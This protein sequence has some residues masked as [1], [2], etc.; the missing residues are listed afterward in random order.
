MMGEWTHL[1]PAGE[2]PSCMPTSTPSTPRS[3]SGT[4]DAERQAG[5]GGNRRGP[6]GLVR[7]QGRR[8]T[9]GDERG[10]TPT[11]LPNAM[12]IPPRMKAYSA[13]SKLVMAC[14]AY[15]TPV[16]EGLSVDEAFLDVGGSKASWGPRETA[17]EL[18]VRVARGRSPISVGIAR[19]KFLAKVASAPAKPDGLIEVPA[20]REL[21]F[22]DPLPVECVWGVGRVTSRQAAGGRDRDCRP[23]RRPRPRHPGGS[24]GRRGRPPPPCSR[25]QP[26]PTRR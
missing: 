14:F 1:R 7:G 4:S 25:P 26:G 8:R 23:D 3:S 21:D 9:V 10:R 17:E 19:T 12:I 11:S 20:R 18:R 22:L 24:G 15:V 13:A 6:G 16:V 5:S 2:P